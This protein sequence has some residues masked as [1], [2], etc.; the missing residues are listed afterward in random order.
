MLVFGNSES[1]IEKC[2]VC[3][4]EIV[5]DKNTKGYALLKSGKKPTKHISD[6][7]Q[8]MRK[9]EGQWQIMLFPYEWS[10]IGVRMP[11][12]IVNITEID[13]LKIAFSDPLRSLVSSQQNCLYTTDFC[14]P[15]CMQQFID[16]FHDFIKISTVRIPPLT[17]E[18][19]EQFAL[20]YSKLDGDYVSDAFDMV[21]FEPIEDIC[22]YSCVVTT[23]S[24]DHMFATIFNSLDILFA[25]GGIGDLP[26]F[27]YFI[28]RKNYISLKA[29][30]R[31]LD[32]ISNMKCRFPTFICPKS[33]TEQNKIKVLKWIL[34]KFGY[35]VD[36]CSKRKTVLAAV[37]KHELSVI[38]FCSHE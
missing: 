2:K 17:S 11:P 13:L 38:S 26:G 25:S 9:Y 4:S 29:L 18:E 7:V 33:F 19:V 1:E 23:L 3:G 27:S 8:W 16:N 28:E 37:E 30:D 31:M 36:R 35:N 22:G 14:K 12:M 21:P 20:G 6:S 34:H 10:S 24:L 15:E 32:I 5:F